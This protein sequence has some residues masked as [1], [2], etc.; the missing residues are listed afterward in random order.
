MK[1]YSNL[2]IDTILNTNINIK[3]LFHYLYIITYIR[4]YRFKDRRY[5]KYDFVPLNIKTLR[6]VISHDYTI[7]FVKELIEL[8]LIESD[9][10]F[11]RKNHKSTGYRLTPLVMN[12]KFYVPNKT[13]EKLVSKIKRV[14]D[15]L[16]LQL[17]KEDN[18]GYGYVTECMEY[19]AIDTVSAHK[20]IENLE[21]DKKEV[22]EMAIDNFGDKFFKKDATGNRLHNNLTNL[23]TPLRK[24]LTYKGQKLIQCDV[25]NSQLIFLYL[26]ML[27]F[28]I[29]KDEMSKFKS[30][31]CDYGFYEFFAEKLNVVLTDDTRKEFKEGI[32][33]HLLF[34]TNKTH[35]TK[36]EIIFK[37]EF[38]E[39]FYVIRHIKTDNYKQLS[40]MLQRK[41]SEFIF[42]CVR[43]INKVIPLFT[44]HDSIA[45][46]I[47][48]EDIVLR[49][50]NDEFKERFNITPKIKTEKFA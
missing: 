24:H 46:T 13:D 39:I 30:V 42:D 20:E 37:T 11:S 23:F 8:G 36:T 32:F 14:Y 41:E 18:L 10:T 4:T 47:G 44:I 21:T 50:M 25:R 12:H 26:L 27:D 15:K 38:P 1:F 19:L 31:V 7:K 40:I 2:Y 48:N 6:K 43:K 49:V 22:A 9:N 5:S 16:K 33:E 34:G 45:T 35:L 17:I 29:N 3:Y 28:N